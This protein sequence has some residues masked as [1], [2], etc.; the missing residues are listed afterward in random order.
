VVEVGERNEVCNCKL[1]TCVGLR[2]I[3]ASV[4][5]NYVEFERLTKHF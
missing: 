5:L 1:F 2:L 4:G 3:R